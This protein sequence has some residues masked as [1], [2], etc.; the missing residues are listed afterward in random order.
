MHLF[1]ALR[2]AFTA[3]SCADEEDEAP[4]A[5]SKGKG[6]SKAKSTAKKR[7]GVPNKG[8]VKRTSTKS[9]TIMDLGSLR[10]AAPVLLLL[11]LLQQQELQA[12]SDGQGAGL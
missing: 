2:Q 3:V 12:C 5:K 11:L 10:H 1:N 7:V 6:K 4:K 9:A 8:R